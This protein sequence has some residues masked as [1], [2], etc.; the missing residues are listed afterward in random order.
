LIGIEFVECFH[1]HDEF[2]KGT[3]H[4]MLCPDCEEV[5]PLCNDCYIHLK[6]EGIIDD[7]DY[8]K[9][10]IHKKILEKHK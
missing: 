3:G 10:D 1:C 8:S 2:R 6:K 9:T 4:S 5:R 7:T